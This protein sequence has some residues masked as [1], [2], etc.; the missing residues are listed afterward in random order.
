MKRMI[1]VTTLSLIGVVAHSQEN[2]ALLVEAVENLENIMREW[3]SSWMKS[4]EINDPELTNEQVN[5]IVAR[6]IYSDDVAEVEDTL[7][8]LLDYV[9]KVRRDM[10]YFTN[11]PLQRKLHQIPGLKNLLI[12]TWREYRATE[13]NQNGNSSQVHNEESLQNWHGIPNILIVLFP[14]DD[15][16]HDIVW[17]IHDARYP[18]DTLMR[19]NIGRFNNAKAN[20]Y[21]IQSLFIDPSEVTIG[22]L[23]ED[24]NIIYRKGGSEALPLA[25]EIHR[26][27]ALGLGICQTDEGFE[28]L[29]ER[30]DNLEGPP[31]PRNPGYEDVIARR[32]GAF[33]MEAIVAHGE[34][35]L[36]YYKKLKRVGARMGLSTD[37]K[38]EKPN[39]NDF[40]G[41]WSPTWSQYRFHNALKN[42]DRLASFD[43]R[44]SEFNA[45]Q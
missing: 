9:T 30:L 10:E 1:L 5:E 32:L 15:E 2:G 34:K 7:R 14:N 36:P 21:R 28:A 38:V 37:V 27:A 44:A 25:N 29:V 41:T 19:L 45:T 16:V 31:D 18:Q 20:S 17:E 24:Q 6:G 42:L 33:V 11:P 3:S 40:I 4:E 22:V 35:A 43:K 39:K 8:M 23:D 13:K 12:R 26:L